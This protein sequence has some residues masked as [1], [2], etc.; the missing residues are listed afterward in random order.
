MYKRDVKLI[1]EHVLN[2]G[3]QGIVDVFGTAIA[4][5]RT[6]F[7]DMVSLSNDIRINKHT[8]KALWG[9]KQDSYSEVVS[10]KEELY[11][12]FESGASTRMIL[13]T[14]LSIKGL[15]LAKASFGLQMLGYNLA[16]LDT[17]NL[18]RLG[19][20]SAYFNRKN[21]TSEYVS[22]VQEK[23]AEYWWDTWC[24]LIPNTPKNRKHFTTADEVSYEHVKAVKGY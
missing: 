14:V 24:E 16:C 10:R 2:T 21:K 15:G 23:G 9:H 13:N 22:V 18:Q 17:H 3:S 11:D 12:L 4:T 5:I 19:Y 6:S 8:S 20:S 1:Q 7:K